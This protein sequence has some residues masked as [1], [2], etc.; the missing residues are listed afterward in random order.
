VSVLFNNVLKDETAEGTKSEEENSCQN[1]DKKDLEFSPKIKR[2]K[3]LTF[4][5]MLLSHFTHK[6]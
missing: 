5:S 1:Q 2:G 6:I 3:V 4:H